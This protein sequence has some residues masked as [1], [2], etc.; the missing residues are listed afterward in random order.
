MPITFDP[1]V[2]KSRG[3]SDPDRR[4]HGWYGSCEVKCAALYMMWNAM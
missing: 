2:P 1:K 4:L 3:R